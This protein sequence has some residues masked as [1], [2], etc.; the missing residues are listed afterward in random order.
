MDVPLRG[1][2][3]PLQY[4]L[5]RFDG[6]IQKDPQGVVV[7]VRGAFRL[8]DLL[9]D[10]L[11]RLRVQGDEREREGSECEERPRTNQDF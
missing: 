8:D 7:P 11:R 4:L 10:L 2:S 1:G 6:V 9:D 5:F 3:D